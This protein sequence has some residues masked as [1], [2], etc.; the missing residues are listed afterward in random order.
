[1]ASIS[2]KTGR[3]IAK[4]I[5]LDKLPVKPETVEKILKGFDSI[6][7]FG[8]VLTTANRVQV[9]KSATGKSP[10]SDPIFNEEETAV[11]N[12]QLATLIQGEFNGSDEEMLG[13]LSDLKRFDPAIIEGL[14]INPSLAGGR[15]ETIGR[16][17]RLLDE[18]RFEEEIEVGGLSAEFSVFDEDV[19]ASSTGEFSEE[20]EGLASLTGLEEFGGVLEV[21]EAGEQIA[22]AGR[23]KTCC[24]FRS[25]TLRPEGEKNK[26]SLNGKFQINLEGIVTITVENEISFFYNITG[27][28]QVPRSLCDVSN[29]FCEDEK[30]TIEVGVTLNVKLKMTIDVLDLDKLFGSDAK[31]IN[32]DELSGTKK[33]QKAGIGANAAPKI[34]GDIKATD[35]K[36]AKIILDHEV[37]NVVKSYTYLF[38]CETLTFVGSTVMPAVGGKTSKPQGN[39]GSGSGTGTSGNG[40]SQSENTSNSVL[41]AVTPICDYCDPK[42]VIPGG[43][44]SL[45]NQPVKEVFQY[46]AVSGGGKY[47]KTTQGGTLLRELFEEQWNAS[48]PTID[49]VPVDMDSAKMEQ[50][51]WIVVKPVMP[52]N[53]KLEYM[54]YY[55]V[56]NT[57][58]GQAKRV[59]LT[60]TSA[61]G[62]S[63][64]PVAQVP[65]LKPG[66]CFAGAFHTHPNTIKEYKDSKIPD[67]QF[68]EGKAGFNDYVFHGQFPLPFVIRGRNE[69]NEGQYVINELDCK[70]LKK[71][72]AAKYLETVFSL[73][74]LPKKP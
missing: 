21:H 20:D 50:G 4:L 10:G 12:E 59:G 61:G 69:N 53:G 42:P 67:E 46:T 6:L 49:V 64:N 36:G 25:A 41:K 9:C 34:Q 13:V 48:N 73:A 26:Q 16:M 28:S 22:E 40:N 71:P 58:L 11:L 23:C 19:E 17:I 44:T 30:Y 56:Q 27:I 74:S 70:N 5:N 60:M 18:S 24:G 63:N 51:G 54:K 38:A 37:K 29:G 35:L 43:I 55:K 45:L 8:F 72:N 14:R 31:S 57:F 47:V 7:P 68:N 39:S 65:E 3:I 62:I 33:L 1:M 66:E 32:F 52:L 15:E 2:Q